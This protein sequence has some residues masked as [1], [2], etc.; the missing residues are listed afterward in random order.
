MRLRRKANRENVR[1]KSEDEKHVRIL[2][3]AMIRPK[4]E[5]VVK[6]AGTPLLV[7]V[8]HRRAIIRAVLHAVAP[9]GVL[10][11]EV[12]RVEEDKVLL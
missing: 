5:A 8:I 7:E 11:E 6:V 10:R 4:E 2:S 3:G 12:P 9:P 1:T